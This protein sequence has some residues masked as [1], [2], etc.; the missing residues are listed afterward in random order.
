MH[1]HNVN[2]AGVSA[3]RSERA[4]SLRCW[5]LPRKASIPYPEA[6]PSPRPSPRKRGEGVNWGPAKPGGGF[7][8][9]VQ[10]RLHVSGRAADD[11]EY[12]AGRGLVFE[13]FVALG[14]AFGKL[15]LQVGYKLFG[16]G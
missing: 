4:R 11:V 16:V 1:L 5:S 12:V 15:T 14:S 10:H 8:Y 7:D 2:S 3:R 13:R 6:C 9:C